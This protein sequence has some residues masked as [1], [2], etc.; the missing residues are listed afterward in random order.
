MLQGQFSGCS[1]F[2]SR[3]SAINLS[4]LDSRPPLA[5]A[6]SFRSGP[7]SG[8]VV[9][10]GKGSENERERNQ[11]TGHTLGDEIRVSGGG[12]KYSKKGVTIRCEGPKKGGRGGRESRG[13]RRCT[14][15]RGDL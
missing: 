12:R 1:T 13:E 11:V 7:A 15:L 2:D 14:L 10:R 3:T 5:L 8:D 6:F 4:V 9:R